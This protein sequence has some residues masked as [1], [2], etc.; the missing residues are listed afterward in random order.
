L[1]RNIRYYVA[2]C[3]GSCTCCYVPKSAVSL[4]DIYHNLNGAHMSLLR[5]LQDTPVVQG[6]LVPSHGSKKVLEDERAFCISHRPV[7]QRT[8]L[9]RTVYPVT[10]STESPGGQFRDHRRGWAIE[11]RNARDSS[12]ARGRTCLST[13]GR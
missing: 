10:L 1:G 9:Y 13:L 8:G 12:T 6:R 4:H 3:K 11:R 5:T 2:S 7:P